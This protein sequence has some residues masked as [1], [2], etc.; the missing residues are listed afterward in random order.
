[1][2][3]RSRVVAALEAKKGRFA[4]YQV[5]LRDTLD[6]YREALERLPSLS[7]AEIEAKFSEAEIGWPGALPTGEQDQLQDAVVSQKQNRANHEGARA[8]AKE[9]LLNTPTFAVDGS[10]ISPSR[11]A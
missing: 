6:R 7:Q 10:Q 9:I 4:D 11:R 1:M 2:L 3:V 5:E 8:W